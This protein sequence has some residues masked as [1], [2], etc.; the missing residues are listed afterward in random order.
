MDKKTVGAICRIQ[1]EEIEGHHIYRRLG[2]IMKS[3]DNARILNEIAGQELKHYG[4]LKGY[5]GVEVKPSLLRVL[6]YVL[7]ARVLGLMFSLKLM[8]R[9]EHA[10]E[11]TYSGIGAH[12]PEVE[13]ILRDEDAHEASLIAMIDEERL[14]YIGSIVLGL[15]DALVE[16]TGALAGF[17]FAIQNSRTIAMLGLITGIAATLSMASSEFLSR[18][19]EDEAPEGTRA[20]KS[21]VYTGIAYII[22]VTILVLPYFLFG[23]PFV[24][25][26]IM[27]A[28]VMAI[29]FSF[30]F[31]ISVAKETPF[32]PGFLRMAL[33]SIG[34]ALI[35]FGI[36][37]FARTRLGFEL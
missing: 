9:G 16:L 30:T 31:Y 32:F 26:V 29:I 18:S 24:S 34:V 13:S 6:A 10:A 8:E 17:T 11:E 1:K 4:V 15:N 2:A 3:A 22:T 33:I 7:M 12:V 20:L 21:S 25:L 28:S 37:W 5:T 14:R 36:G 23:N 35:S 27:L 19:H